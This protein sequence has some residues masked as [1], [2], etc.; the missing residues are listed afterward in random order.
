MGINY[1]FKFA[2]VISVTDVEDGGRIKAHISGEDPSAY[3]IKDI[4]YAFPMLPK[5]FF[6]KPQV[7]E[8][9]FI[10]K[11]YGGSGNDRFYIGPIISQPHKLPFDTTTAESF[12]KGGLVGPE[13]APSTIPENRGVQPEDDDIGLIGRGSTDI[14]QKKDQVIVRAGKS[15]DL[16]TLNIENQAYT[17]VKYNRKKKRG[18]INIVGD[19][20]NLLSPSGSRVFNTNTPKDM[21]TDE[22]FE[23]ILSEAENLP[24]GNK[25]KDYLT[26]Q[27]LAFAVHVHPYAG[28]PP[29]PEQ[30]EVSDYLNYDIQEILSKKIRC[31]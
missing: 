26:K 23:R 21:I 15:L 18:E 25:L 11:Q 30:K 27:R 7:G 6:I 3:D 10:V 16:K 8:K 9:V 29:D 24:L 22:E 1:V 4:P 14:M 20:I 17:Q 12:I 2:T 5:H 13:T 19:Y 31:N 28:L